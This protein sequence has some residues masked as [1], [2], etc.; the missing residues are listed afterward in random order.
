MMGLFRAEFLRL[1]KRRSLQII[2][3]GVPALVAV[4]FIA[5]Y[6]SL[7][8]LPP[9]NVDEVRANLIANGY[10]VGLP[11]DEAE[12]MIQEGIAQERMFYDM[13]LEQVK[14][15]RAGH[16]FPYSLA[17]V[18]QSG[19]IVFFALVILAATTTG[20]EFG[21]GTIRTTLIASSHRHRVLAVR[22]TALAVTAVALFTVLLLLGAVLQS[23]LGVA[24]GALPATLPAFD[25]GALAV[26]LGGL[27]L[28]AATVMATTTLITLL[29][30][31]GALALAA[32]PVYF[33][34][35]AA[36][37]LL[38]LRF[39]PFGQDGDLAWVLDG[40]PLRGLTWITDHVGRAATGL[41]GYPG[42]AVSRAIDTAAL[43][44]T[45][46]AVIAVVL[47][48]LSFRCFSRM[49]IAE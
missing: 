47:T 35:E 6:S 19:T 40:F 31:N 3:L 32:I 39:E 28:G 21:W 15:A 17:T 9:F 30:R 22:L 44:M 14:L 34:V 29:A 25:A 41:P 46:F 42:E 49:D 2:V 10:G 37:L 45:T 23:L 18:L 26:L 11:P 12:R 48:A 20:D 24:H 13:Q 16:V 1:R 5:S 43:P 36:V 38:L 7:T 4:I 27:L 8:Q 33:A